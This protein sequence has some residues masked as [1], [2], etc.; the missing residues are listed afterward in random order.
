M[1][2]RAIV[3]KKWAKTGLII[4]GA[5]FVVG[6][7][8]AIIGSTMNVPVIEVTR[9][10]TATRE[11][12]WELWADV[13]NRTRWDADLEYTRLDGPFQTGSTGEVKLKGQPAGKF[14]IT[15]C[16]PLEG[17]TDRFF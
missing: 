2:R 4:G 14:L 10:T 8:G 13:P 7:P 5:L 1:V 17:Y 9:K 15:Y 12:V 3:R 11:Q 16:E 6:I